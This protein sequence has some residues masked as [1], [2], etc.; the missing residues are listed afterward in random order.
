MMKWHDSNPGKRRFLACLM[1]AAWIVST[2]QIYQGSGNLGAQVKNKPLV[3][4]EERIN[5]AE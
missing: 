5:F 1:A 2:L 4:E 3:I